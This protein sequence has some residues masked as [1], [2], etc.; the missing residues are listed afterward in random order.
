VQVVGENVTTPVPEIF[1]QVTVPVCDGYP[2]DT[3]AMQVI[4]VVWKQDTEVNVGAFWTVSLTVR[5]L[6]RLFESPLYVPCSVTLPPVVPV[7]VTE[8]AP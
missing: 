8:H 5:E 3:Y 4:G 2:P 7:I 6:P 1:N